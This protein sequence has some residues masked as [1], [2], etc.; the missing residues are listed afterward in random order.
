MLWNKKSSGN[1]L[2]FSKILLFI[3]YKRIEW[4]CIFMK[5]FKAFQ[6]IMT[7]SSSIYVGLNSHKSKMWI[8]SVIIFVPIFSCIIGTHQ[9]YIHF[10]EFALIGVFLG[11][12]TICRLKLFVSFQCNI[13]THNKIFATTILPIGAGIIYQLQ[14]LHLW[15]FETEEAKMGNSTLNLL[16]LNKGSNCTLKE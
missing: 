3:L 2:V 14:H 4:M 7:K 16:S 15:V 5:I 1:F 6:E 10:L 13:N 12:P 11:L 8:W 9:S